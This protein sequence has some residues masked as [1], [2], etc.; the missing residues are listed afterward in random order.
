[1]SK[2]YT[3][4]DYLLERLSEL[5]ADRIFD[6]PGVFTLAMLDHIER[7]ERMQWVGCANEL[8]AGYAADGYARI[9]GIGVLCT[10]F[11]AGNCHRC[12]RGQL[13]VAGVSRA[14]LG[15]D[16]SRG[17]PTRRAAHRRI[18]VKA[19]VCG[20]HHMTGRFLIPQTT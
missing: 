17:A 20:Y 2:A 11:G 12:Y 10:T 3:V 15:S 6:V 16:G 13:P 14:A 19:S 8:G 1:M 7:N 18:R 9:R 4:V 5:G